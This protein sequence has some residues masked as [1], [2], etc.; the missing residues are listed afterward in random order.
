MGGSGII[1]AAGAAGDGEESDVQSTTSEPLDWNS[2]D[3]PPQDHIGDVQTCSRDGMVKKCIEKVGQGFGRPGQYDSVELRYQV[4]EGSSEDQKAGADEDLPNEMAEAS[5]FSMGQDQLP[6]AVEFAV[7]C[8]RLGEVAEVTGPLAYATMLSPLCGQKLRNAMGKA[9]A[10]TASRKLRFLPAAPQDVCLQ[11]RREQREQEMKKADEATASFR[12]RVELCAVHSVHML[13]EDR[14]VSKQT[15]QQGVGRRTPRIGDL[16]HFSM[17]GEGSEGS[18]ALLRSGASCTVTEE[19]LSEKDPCPSVSSSSRAHVHCSLLLDDAKLPVEGL[20]RVLLSMKEGERC[21]AW[22]PS[23]KE[24]DESCQ[25]ADADARR[26]VR[27]RAEALLVT[28]H[29]WQCRDEVVLS[30]PGR[31]RQE[32]ESSL[33][34]RKFEL[35]K[36][37]QRLAFDIEHGSMVLAAMARSADPCDA[38]ALGAPSTLGPTSLLTWCWGEGAVP[39]YIEACLTG[40]RIAESAVFSAP[41]AAISCLRPGPSFEGQTPLR[42]LE[43]P[44]LTENVCSTLFES[45]DH[46]RCHRRLHC[47]SPTMALTTDNGSGTLSLSSPVISEEGASS[48]LTSGTA[49]AGLHSRAIIPPPDWDETGDTVHWDALQF[50]GAL[51][52]TRDGQHEDDTA[53]GSYTCFK[54]ALLAAREAPDVCTLADEQQREYLARERSHGNALVKMGRHAEASEAYG[55]A[56]DGVRRSPLYKALFPT[57]RGRIQGAYSKD[58]SEHESPLEQLRPEDVE[59]WRTGLVA[60]HLNLALCAAKEGQNS[61]ARKHCSVVLGAEPKSSKALFRRGA[62]AS[63]QGD[64]EVALRDLQ[65]AQELEPQDRA[66]QQ[67]LHTLQQKMRQHRKNERNTFQNLFQPRPRHDASR[68]DTGRD[69]GEVASEEPATAP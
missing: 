33:S 23:T 69:D 30:P 66:I 48:C 6:L 21:L 9:A 53:S 29:C 49:D 8:M 18:A 31:A 37:M 50:E 5:V 28:M 25:E 24:K 15:L 4:L 12:A 3:E 52:V 63:A 13:T 11:A 59:A 39:G 42:R 45:N 68:E 61:S 62:A 17:E 58:P 26:P 38:A 44:G 55:R 60:L 22:L 19:V 10:A 20:G 27:T 46:D 32:G 64:Y 43:L 65:Q 56:L 41:A 16:V 67:E 54:L 36:G 47:T 7:K 14:T 40:M 57:E 35:Q 51:P 2:D 34:I 1:D